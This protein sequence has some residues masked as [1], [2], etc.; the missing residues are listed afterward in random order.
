MPRNKGVPGSASAVWQPYTAERLERYRDELAAHAEERYEWL[1]GWKG[2]RGKGKGYSDEPAASEYRRRFPHA[3]DGPP[4]RRGDGDPDP[5]LPPRTPLEEATALRMGRTAP[6]IFAPQRRAV[7]IEGRPVVVPTLGRARSGGGQF[8]S[9][10]WM[11]SQN[12]S[13]KGG[14]G[15]TGGH[16]FGRSMRRLAS[17][18]SG[19]GVDH[20]GEGH[21]CEKAGGGRIWLEMM[22]GPESLSRSSF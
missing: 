6:L 19:A 1:G 7:M 2:G 21:R 10:A 17:W 8:L 12:L 18:L 15:G 11:L 4:A 22:G 5:P 13:G 20:D 3:A 14:S 9:A 16:D